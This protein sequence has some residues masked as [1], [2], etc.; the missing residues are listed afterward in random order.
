VNL[1]L[2]RYSWVQLLK[3]FMATPPA[4]SMAGV[5]MGL[6]TNNI[7]PGPDT[8]LAD[9]TEPTY[10]SYAQAAATLP[11][12]AFSDED[13]KVFIDYGDL[14]WSLTTGDTPV[15]IIGAFIVDGTGQLLMA[16]KLDNPVTLT[17]PGDATLIGAQVVVDPVQLYGQFESE[18]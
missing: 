18:P 13:G 17:N 6:F 12:G 3:R 5:K 15:T 7:S 9:L 2:M 16:G 14:T 8:V 11:A 4:F 10:A 1:I